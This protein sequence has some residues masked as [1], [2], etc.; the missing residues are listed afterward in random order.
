MYI[1]VFDNIQAAPAYGVYIS[2]LIAYHCACGS[3]YGLL[4][5]GVLLAMTQLLSQLY[6]QKNVV[7]KLK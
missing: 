3:Y 2:W 5:R 4:D 7:V 1:Y 6:L